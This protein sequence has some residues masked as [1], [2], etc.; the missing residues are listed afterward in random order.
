[1]ALQSFMTSS[2]LN[3]FLLYC[4]ITWGAGFL[5]HFFFSVKGSPFRNHSTSTGALC[6]PLFDWSQ[7]GVVHFEI[8]K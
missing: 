6:Q 3:H 2:T 7:I 8:L 5:L 4:K 1:M